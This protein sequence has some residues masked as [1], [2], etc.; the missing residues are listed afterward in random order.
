M[1]QVH[2]DTIHYGRTSPVSHAE[3]CEHPLFLTF[4]V[5][6][7]DHRLCPGEQAA[8]GQGVGGKERGGV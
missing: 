8:A 1:L 6:F 4:R 3:A 2:A 5:G 7:Q